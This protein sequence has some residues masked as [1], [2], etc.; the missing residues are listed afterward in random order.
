VSVYRD[1]WHCYHWDD[2]I[3]QHWLALLPERRELVA[4]RILR[5]LSAVAVDDTRGAAAVL[6]LLAESGG[7]A[8]DAVHLCVAYGLGARHEEDRLAAVDALLVLAARGQLDVALLGADLGQ[9]V[10]REAAKPSR[11]A[12][13]ARMA[14]ATGANATIWGLLRHT[15]PLLLADLATG[16]PGGQAAKGRG[17]GE[18]L[19]VAAECAERAVQKKVGPHDLEASSVLPLTATQAQQDRQ[20]VWIH[21]LPLGHKAFVITQHRSSTVAA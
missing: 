12:E 15:L 21:S 17:L 3:R 16:G 20:K 13:S 5:D 8:G 14:A 9:L 1:R 6:P 4:A 11:L 7:E 18:L 2:A 19:T 10:R